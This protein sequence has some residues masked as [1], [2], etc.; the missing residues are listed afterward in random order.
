MFWRPVPRAFKDRKE[1]GKRERSE[2]ER[3]AT[4]ARREKG[5]FN[6]GGSNW[7]TELF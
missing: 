1:A 7:K 4:E 6:A 5:D 3:G 2:R